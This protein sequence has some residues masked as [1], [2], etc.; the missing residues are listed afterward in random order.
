MKP[1]NLISAYQ[2]AAA[3]ECAD[4][5]V[6]KRMIDLKKH[7]IRNTESFCKLMIANG[8]TMNDFDGFFV[9]YTINQI[10]K[11]FDLLR[12]G[13]AGILNIELKSE[14]KMSKE[15]KHKKIVEQMRKNYYYLKF[16]KY[17][18]TI[19]TY[20]E[21]DGFYQYVPEIDSITVVESLEVSKYIKDQTVDYGIDPDKEFIPSNYLISP[22]NSTEAFMNGE[23]FLTSAQ[24]KIENQINDELVENPSKF[25]CISANA[26]TGKTLL[27]YDI[28]KKKI[29][30]G[31]NLLI[32]HCGIL[33]GGHE[34]LR[35]TYGWNIKS[36]RVIPYSEDKID[37]EGID[38]ILLDE[39]QRIRSGQLNALIKKAC[40]CKIPIIFSYDPKQYL[41]TGETLDV[42][43]FLQ[44]NYP[45]VS[46]SSKKLTNKI[47]TNKSLSSFINNL[48]SI[49]KSTDN[50]DYDNITIE[51]AADLD[52]LKQHIST[53]VAKGWVPITYTT[54]QYNQDPYDDVYQ[55]CETT[56]HSVIGQEFSK[57]VFVMDKNFCYDSDGKLWARRSY[58][59]AKGMLYQIATRVVDELKIIVLDNPD[60]Y[61][62]LLNIK[63][64]G[65]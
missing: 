20:V 49:G 23:Y 65:M 43:A 55:I 64:M 21:N 9:S 14:L 44:T 48:L 37:L 47:R 25:F 59:D 61:A 38:C 27:L 56:A 31:Y 62:N 30:C 39:S 7:E 36:V 5:D 19:Y 8:C 22:F 1:R 60:L 16:L 3:L 10:S 42:A 34:K 26:G 63:A 13:T 58:Y 45:E 46:V 52:V 11:E 35:D 50:L 40:E 6:E 53:L 41:R 2:G 32:I 51:Y 29:S 4:V 24:Q 15:Q 17:P 54:S 12:F 18:I 33:N 57:V 28:A